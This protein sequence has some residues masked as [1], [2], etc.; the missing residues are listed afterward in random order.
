[1]IDKEDARRIKET[2]TAAAFT[3]WLQGA[4]DKD[5][6]PQF[7][8]KYGLLEKEKPMTD[9]KKKKI[10]EKSKHVAARIMAM[11]KKRKKK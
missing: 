5:N 2:M 1:M 6:F 3:A 10:L 8:R 7:L 9:E 11:D 4:G